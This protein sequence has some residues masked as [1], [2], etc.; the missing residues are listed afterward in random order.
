MEFDLDDP[1]GDLLSDGSN[2][3]FFGTSKKVEST[4]SSKPTTRPST[5]AQAK[6]KVADLFG[7]DSKTTEKSAEIDLKSNVDLNT[8]QSRSVYPS[9]EPKK[10]LTKE[11][12]VGSGSVNPSHSIPKKSSPSTR[13]AQPSGTISAV[14]AT[15]RAAMEPSK[16][17]KKE[18]RFDDDSDD[19]LNELGFDPKNPRGSAKKTN[20]LDDILN[21]SKIDAGTK[22]SA[23]SNAAPKAIPID[24]DKRAT[25]PAESNR[26]SPSLGGRPRSVPRSG[27]GGSLGDP[28]G[29]FAKQTPD[30]KKDE[31]PAPT[32]RPKSSKKPTVDWL[33]LDTADEIKPSE[34]ASVPTLPSQANVMT[35][36]SKPMQTTEPIP[37]VSSASVAPTITL[38]TSIPA[39]R[40]S[41]AA[42]LSGN[43]NLVNMVA[44]ENEH[45]LHSLQQ[46]ETQ[47][48]VAAQMKQQENMLHDMHSKQQVLI[49]L[50]E[51]QFN[52][53]VRRQIER[54]NH[55]ETQIHQQ[56]EQ[57][58]AYISV[59]MNQPSIGLMTVNKLPA[60]DTDDHLE[61]RQDD[62]GGGMP[63]RDFIELEADV[64]RLELEKLRLEDTLQSVQTAHEQELEL[65][66]ISHK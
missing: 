56:Q 4:K 52:E 25:K 47:L 20:I 5:D 35:E 36:Y 44:L 62:G 49:K 10:V 21:F 59:L 60:S 61:N 18:T 64:K 43:L 23:A 19:F 16:S 58:N 50:Q 66:H 39:A 54:Q 53:L 42:D 51:N 57:I 6:S 41:T 14:D 32:T 27:S 22:T 3:S 2:D 9:V 37:I 31:N 24:A 45:A 46:Q 55:L 38:P 13:V 28:L 30:A 17:V 34:M 12:S 33:G 29:I 40:P 48:R 26:Y 7:F 65:L 11:E 63:R 15:G 8:T 1:L